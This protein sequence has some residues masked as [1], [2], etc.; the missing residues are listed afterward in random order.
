M[1]NSTYIAGHE[2][3]QDFVHRIHRLILTNEKSIHKKL[4]HNPA[5]FQFEHLLGVGQFFL[6]A[7]LLFQFASALI[8]NL[9]T[10]QC[11]N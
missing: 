7:R 5:I 4:D 2:S 9:G 10:L 3:L 1:S 11:E 6:A 8:L